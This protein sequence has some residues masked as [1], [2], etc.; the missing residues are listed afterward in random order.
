MN[1]CFTNITCHQNY[2]TTRSGKHIEGIWRE[3]I[4]HGEVSE[5]VGPG[6]K[7]DHID[8]D[9]EDD[10]EEKKLPVVPDVHHAELMWK[11]LLNLLEERLWLWRLGWNE[12][13][14]NAVK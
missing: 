6:Y 2:L 11:G 4:E 7:E 3:S 10:Q 8:G 9:D 14:A 12:P 5:V 1:A 13:L